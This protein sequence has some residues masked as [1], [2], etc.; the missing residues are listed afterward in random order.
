M[1]LS[2]IINRDGTCVLDLLASTD[3]LVDEV[4]CQLF[5]GVSFS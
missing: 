4:G 5:K 2:D 3:N 1:V